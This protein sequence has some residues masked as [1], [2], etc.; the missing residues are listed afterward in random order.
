MMCSLKKTRVSYQR[1][2]IPIKNRKQ[3]IKALSEKGMSKT[4]IYNR[5]FHKGFKE[6]E[7][8][9]ISSC[10]TEYMNLCDLH[11][12]EDAETASF[13]KIQEFYNFLPSKMSFLNFMKSKGMGIC[14]SI[15]YFKRKSFR[16][17]E[18]EGVA[19]IINKFL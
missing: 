14:T 1:K 2:D 18:M 11:L 9:G 13:E 19:E 6:W 12:I 10:M 8:Q 15:A 5:L 16:P 7:M 4:K 17:Y 3:M